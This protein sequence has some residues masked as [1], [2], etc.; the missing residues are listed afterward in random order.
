M[1][2]LKTIFLL[3]ASLSLQAMGQSKLPCPVAPSG[4]NAGC[5]FVAENNLGTESSQVKRQI[6][7]TYIWVG[8]FDPKKPTAVMLAGGPGDGML[9][10]MHLPFFQILA[11][12]TNVLLYDQRG[13][14]FSGALT[15]SNISSRDLNQYQIENSVKDLEDLRQ[16]LLGAGTKWIVLGHSY[17]AHLAYAYA[18]T[19]P[20]SVLALVPI[21]GGLDTL[22][23]VLQPGTKDKLIEKLFSQHPMADRVPALF[24]L[25]DSGKAVD[26]KGVP[27]DRVSF[28][29]AVSGQLSSAYGQKKYFNEYLSLVLNANAKEIDLLLRARA[30][31]S[32]A[33]IRLTDVDPS[34]Q[35]NP[36][37]NDL[38]VCNQLMDPGQIAKL[39]EPEKASAASTRQIICSRTT[40][41]SK[42][43]FF[44]VKAQFLRSFSFP[45]MIVSGGLDPL[46]PAVVQKRD[47]ELMK[48]QRPD[49]V[50]VAYFPNAGHQL[51]DPEMEPTESLIGRL[52]SFLGRRGILR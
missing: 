15:P 23:W 39:S 41:L 8:N 30:V 27:L 48:K 47:F 52:I 35:M 22:G 49:L 34:G 5:F 7:M 14:G 9:P 50:E 42:T 40:K 24:S 29:R 28:S 18:A 2:F 10:L 16:H 17:G 4:F 37:I 44:D 51:M 31:P 26:R 36:I 43:R 19:Y 1:N 38:I 25:I 45:T 21:A 13:I 12:K 46:I 20:Q 6:R 33:P 11:K 32:G 3:C